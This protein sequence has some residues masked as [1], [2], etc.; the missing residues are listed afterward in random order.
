[1]APGGA[2]TFTN[3]DTAAHHDIEFDTAGCPTVGDIPPGGQ[4]RT[5]FP[6]QMPCTFH[7]GNNASNAAFKGTVAVTAVIVSGGGY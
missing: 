7:D 1:V 5:I 4:V 3:N 6:T 2:V